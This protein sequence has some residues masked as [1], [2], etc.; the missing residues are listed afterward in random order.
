MQFLRFTSRVCQLGLQNVQA[1]KLR[2]ILTI[3]GIVFGVSSVI[4]MLSIGEGA[5][6]EVLDQ[7]RELGSQNI[8]I[9][10]VEPPRDS[11][12]S[13][14]Q[15]SPFQA[16]DYGL[17][18]SDAEHLKDVIPT[19]EVLVPI[20]SIS[21]TVRFGINEAQVSVLGTVPWYPQSVNLP[22]K[23]GRFLSTIDLNEYINVC[24]ISHKLARTLFFYHEPIG[25]SIR[26]GKNAY[27]VIGIV[28]ST[29]GH[30]GGGTSDLPSQSADVFVPL[31]T[32]KAYEGD[33]FIDAQSG[34]FTSE[35]VELRELIV[36]VDSLDAVIPTSRLVEDIL[37]RVHKKKDYEVIVPLQLLE[38]ARR[39]QAIFSIVLGSIAA[40]SLL[41]GGI[42]IMNIMLAS[43]SE[44]T[45]EI[46]VRRAMGARRRD[47][48]IQF[49]IECLILSIGGGVIGMGLGAAIPQFVTRFSG[50]PTVLTLD[51]FILAFGISVMVGIVFGLYPARRA[52]MMDPIEALRHE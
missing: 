34:A 13:S 25:K 1:H 23:D 38:Q 36:S 9:K 21:S 40:I 31:T 17:R 41:V 16:K 2:S 32:L 50:M 39:T 15:G 35:Y 20:K 6:R 42:G 26:I 33:L 3:S 43:V 52:A 4:S 10:S 29:G 48:T 24:V 12:G 45:R 46:G 49:L 44:R 19:A 18:Y 5:S 22:I 14:A 8:I 11:T 47:I 28:G 27:R 7:I 30:A 51:A 37:A